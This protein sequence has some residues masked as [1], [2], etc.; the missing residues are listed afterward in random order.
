ME[1][2]SNKEGHTGRIVST[3]KGELKATEGALT[4][5][6]LYVSVSTVH[7]CGSPNIENLKED[8]KEK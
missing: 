5:R 6:S 2:G 8:T 1:A 3:Q 4:G 7:H